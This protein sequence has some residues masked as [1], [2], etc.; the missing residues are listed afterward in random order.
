MSGSDDCVG[1]LDAMMEAASSGTSVS[2]YLTLY[3]E[4]HLPALK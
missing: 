3:L 4:N 1:D 2:P